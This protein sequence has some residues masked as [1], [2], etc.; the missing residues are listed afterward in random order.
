MNKQ[1]WRNFWVLV[2]A[3]LGLVA[4][5]SCAGTR[6]EKP[7]Q[8]V[9][10]QLTSMS[11]EQKVGQMMVVTYQP[12]FYN[13]DDPVFQEIL[14]RVRK[15]HVGGISMYRGNPYA[16]A[17]YI[18][19]LQD[20][21]DIPLMVMA[22]M[23]WG[24]SMRVEE[25]TGFLPNMAVGATRS[26]EYAYQEGRITAMEARAIGIH[27]NFAPVM[28]V[29]NNPD[30]LI[31]NTRSYGED[32]ALVARLGSAFIRG[33]QENGVFATAKHFPGH[34]DTNVDSHLGLPT[35]TASKQ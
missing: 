24:V 28:D 29:N 14:D 18:Q 10:R 26:E 16:V 4:L 5:F 7:E 27:V 1:F 34:G 17:R 25:G 20:A 23:E 13:E 6:S 11:L 9:E 12:R 35:V 19:R 31:I 8:W 32:P 3:T 30:N 22:D 15:Y 21:A 2:L 33:L